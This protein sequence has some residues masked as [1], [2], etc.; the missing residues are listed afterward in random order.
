MCNELR[1]SFPLFPDRPDPGVGITKPTESGLQEL[2]CG[3]RLSTGTLAVK[4][5]AKNEL[6]RTIAFSSHALEPMIDECGFADTSPGNDSNNGYFLICPGS[7]QESDVFLSTEKAAS[8][9]GQSGY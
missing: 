3:R 9:N 4:G 2:F 7:I 1:Q 6:R 5:P 8:S